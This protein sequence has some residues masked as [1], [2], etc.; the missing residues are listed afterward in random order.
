MDPIGIRRHHFITRSPGSCPCLG[1]EPPTIE[2][3]MMAG[4]PPA[5]HDTTQ[6]SSHQDDRQLLQ[7]QLL[8]EWRSNRGVS[9]TSTHE[10]PPLCPTPGVAHPAV[11]GRHP[12]FQSKSPLAFPNC[13]QI[14]F[15]AVERKFPLSDRGLPKTCGSF[16]FF[17]S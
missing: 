2:G 11:P 10:H 9:S 12:S 14:H 4:S 6:K 8:R 17:T 7:P 3:L 13:T 16:L 15:S 1:T 5:Y